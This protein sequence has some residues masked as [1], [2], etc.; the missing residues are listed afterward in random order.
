MALIHDYIF[1]QEKLHIYNWDFFQ[2]FEIFNIL[3]HSE[4]WTFSAISR[5]PLSVNIAEI[6]ALHTSYWQCNINIAEISVVKR[7]S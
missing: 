4:K 3:K 1:S 5:G 7:G 6:L 2:Q